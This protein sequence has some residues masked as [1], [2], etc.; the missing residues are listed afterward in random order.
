MCPMW[1]SSQTDRQGYKGPWGNPTARTPAVTAVAPWVIP[2]KTTPVRMI[3]RLHNRFRI[4]INLGAIENS[5]G[6]D[7]LAL[8]VS[9]KYVERIMANAKV[10]LYLESACPE[11]LTLLS[12]LLQ[13]NSQTE[14]NAA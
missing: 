8:A 5:Y 6:T 11:T 13:H 3:T 1:F 14:H 9:R 2:R 7:M 12:G 10:K 4:V